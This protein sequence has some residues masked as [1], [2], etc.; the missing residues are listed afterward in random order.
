M[1]IEKKSFFMKYQPRNIE[2]YIF[3]SDSQKQKV[4]KWLSQ[5]YIDGNLLLS[6]KAGT[7]KT[8]LAEILINNFVKN[9]SDL[10]KI[11]SRSVEEIDN[12]YNWIQ[13]KSI[14]SKK[15]IIYIEEIDRL[16]RVSLIQLK[17]GLLEKF[18]DYVTFIA[19]TNNLKKLEPAILSRFNY[20]P[21]EWTFKGGNKKRIQERISYILKNEN[22]EFAEEELSNFI[23]KNSYMGL[24]ELIN[25]I[26]I[27]IVENSIDF[28]SIELSQITTEDNIIDN[29][30]SLF[31]NVMELK[32]VKE[33]KIIMIDPENS[34]ISKEYLEIVELTQ[35]SPNLDYN[36]IYETLYYKVNFLPLKV[37]FSKYM[38]ELDNKKMPNIH[39]M[40]FISDSIECILRLSI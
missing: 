32:N 9:Q 25:N 37:I 11:K 7:G 2:E 22:I 15:K 20:G 27:N 1:T 16:S 38:E 31:K 18:Q 19:T 29:T 30:I 5:G 12:L 6:G 4:E 40:S 24:R 14:S 35:F 3:E 26:Q 33:K 13:A 23:E 34:A 17:D 8:S 10:K 28:S 36:Y 21:S 39:Y